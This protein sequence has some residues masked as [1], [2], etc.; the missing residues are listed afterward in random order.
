MTLKIEGILLPP[1]SPFSSY[2]LVFP[3][4]TLEGR[5][6][7]RHP[8]LATQALVVRYGLPA[9]PSSAEGAK[10]SSHT[11]GPGGRSREAGWRVE[12]QAPRPLLLPHSACDLCACT[13]SRQMCTCP[14]VC[15]CVG[16]GGFP[17]GS[18]PDSLTVSKRKFRVRAQG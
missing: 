17:P 13:L 3:L 9:A 2:L 1:P 10:A 12:L 5:E 4:T 7:H 15:V 14:S 8:G 11:L 18:T 16:R 6:S